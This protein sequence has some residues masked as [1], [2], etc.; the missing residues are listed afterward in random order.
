MMTCSSMDQPRYK[1]RRLFH[2]KRHNMY[3]TLND[4]I[5]YMQERESLQIEL[6]AFRNVSSTV[7]CFLFAVKKFHV[8]C[9]LLSNHE[10]FLA[11]F[12]DIKERALPLQY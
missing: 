7:Y 5:S 6:T 8:F 2:T 10:T 4:I 11:N 1:P 12:C 3:C 9:G